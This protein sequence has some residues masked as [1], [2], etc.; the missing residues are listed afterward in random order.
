MA[1]YKYF[2]CIAHCAGGCI[3]TSKDSNEGNWTPFTLKGELCSSSDWEE[4]EDIKNFTR[5]K[6]SIKKAEEGLNECLS[7]TGE[8]LETLEAKE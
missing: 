1:K 2:K 8:M 6:E 3:V 5:T 7:I 4:I